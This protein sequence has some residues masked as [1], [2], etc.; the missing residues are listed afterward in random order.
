MIKNS[1][2]QKG[3]AHA[4]LIIGLVVALVGALGLIFW[5][6][7]IH[8]EPLAKNDPIAVTK[9]NDNQKQLA[10]EAE[11]YV[12]VIPSEWKV[13][14][15][16]DPKFSYALPS[17]QAVSFKIYSLNEA[18]SVG[19]GAPVYVKYDTNLG[20]QTYSTDMNGTPTI[21][22]ETN[23]VKTLSAKV[24]DKFL[25]SYYETGDGTAGESRVLVVV[26][27]RVYQFSFDRTLQKPEILT[28][29]AK[30]VDL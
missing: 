11:V 19:Y 20:W 6:N 21:K 7:F 8:K 16:E 28:Q 2:M 14:N 18:I 23:L 30:T 5:Q 13:F 1:Q 26:G 29:F 27:S 17:G 12:P 15:N 24:E 4:L 9:K 25:S 22:A 10:S 3:F